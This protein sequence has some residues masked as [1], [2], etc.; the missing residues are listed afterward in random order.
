MCGPGTEVLARRALRLCRHSHAGARL[1][2]KRTAW[3]VQP[4]RHS[5]CAPPEGECPSLPP[6][7]NDEEQWPC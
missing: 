1:A 4:S 3:H 5:R 7:H 6:G 2:L